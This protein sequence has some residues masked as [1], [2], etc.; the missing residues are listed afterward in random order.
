MIC[1][2]YRENLLTEG[3]PTGYEETIIDHGKVSKYFKNTDAQTVLMYYPS[4]LLMKEYEGY[5]IQMFNKYGIR[6]NN[7][8]SCAEVMIANF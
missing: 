2:S 7:F 8:N 4:K 1:G 6:T 3:Y 5:D